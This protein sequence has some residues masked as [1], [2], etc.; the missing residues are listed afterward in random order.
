MTGRMM[1]AAAAT[2]I[3]RRM[4]QAGRGDASPALPARVFGA[5]IAKAAEAAFGLPVSVAQVSDEAVTLADLAERLEERALLALVEAPQERLG[6]VALAPGLVATVVEMLT[7]GQ[8][9]PAAPAPRRPTRTDAALCAGIIDRVLSETDAGAAEGADPWADWQAGFRY[10]SCV[11]DMRLLPLLL[12]DSHYRLYRCSLALGTDGARQAVLSIVLPEPCRA[13]VGAPG[14][15]AAAAWQGQLAKALLD[16]EAAVTAILARVMRPLA[17]VMA[18]AP[19]ALLMLPDDAIT[20]VRLEGAGRRLLT[21]AR[22]GQYRGYLAVRLTQMPGAQAPCAAA[23]PT[24]AHG[25][26]EF[27]LAL[28]VQPREAL[29]TAG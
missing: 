14:A 28:E 7:T 22:L 26:E 16:S 15:E 11:D 1:T 2:T 3:L 8:M 20:R 17:E 25:G 19:G 13:E 23:A 27:D 9:A 12:D 4:A 5:S 29:A 21:E 24:A 18:L 10:A 6:L